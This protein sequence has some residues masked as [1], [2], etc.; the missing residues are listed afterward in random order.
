[1]RS[2]AHREL[3]LTAFSLYQK[4]LLPVS[5]YSIADIL[6]GF[7]PH[8]TDA[9]NIYVLRIDESETSHPNVLAIPHTM[10]PLRILYIGANAKGASRFNSL[11]KACRKME[12]YFDRHGHS[13][14]DQRHEHS[15]ARRFTTGLLQTGFRINHCILDIIPT[16]KEVNELE[17]II[18]YEETYHRLPPWNAIRGGIAAYHEEHD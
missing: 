5:H 10:D 18:G 8:R 2:E 14:N 13:P 7:I 1:M 12:Q 6:D 16:S 15:I 11:V 4:G 3:S 9:S 17:L